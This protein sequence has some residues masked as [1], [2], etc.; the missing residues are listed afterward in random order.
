MPTPKRQISKKPSEHGPA[1][2]TDVARLETLLAQ[3]LAALRQ[4]RTQ[5]TVGNISGSGIA[6]GTGASAAIVHPSELEAL[7]SLAVDGNARRKEEIYLTWFILGNT[8]A[9]WEREYLPLASSLRYYNLSDAS[10]SQAGLPLDDVRDA[11]RQYHTERLVILGE[12]GAGKTT[13]LYRLAHDLARER[14]RDPAQG[15]LPISLSLANF[16]KADELPADFLLSQWANT[17]LG[18]TYGEAIAYGQACFLLD[19]LNQMPAEDRNKRIDDWRRWAKSESE[20]PA[21]NLAIFACRKAE[22]A[23]LLQLA[24]V[25]VQQLDNDRIQKY[26]HLRFDPEP[27]HKHWRALRD[28]L[29]TGDK[30]FEDLARNAMMLSLLADRAAKGQSLA[31]SKGVILEDAAV[32]RLAYEIDSDNQP[33][34][35]RVKAEAT[36]AAEME[37]LGRI[38]YEVQ[39]V[40]EGTVFDRAA[41]EA[42]PLSTKSPARLTLDQALKL[43]VDSTLLN[44]LGPDDGPPY[45]FRHQLFQEYFAARELLRRFR[46][47]EVLD[48][49]WQ[50]DWQAPDG[51]PGAER[52]DPPPATRWDETVVMLGGL[53]RADAPRLIAAIRAT[54]PP[55][56]GRALAEA[57]PDERDDLKGLADALRG[58]LLERQR[59]LGAR[60]RARISAGLALG[61]LGH[62]DLRPREFEFEGRKVS[63]IAPPMKHV[64]EGEFIRGSAPEE[65]DSFDQE[66]TTERRLTLPAYSAA[67]YPVTNA[68]YRLFIEDGGYDAKGWWSEA[69]WLWRGGG[70]DAHDAA[71]EQWLGTRDLFKRVPDWA[72]QLQR[73]GRTQGTINF[74]KEVVELT[75]EKARDRGRQQFSRS[76][77]RPAFWEDTTLNSPAKPVIGVNWHEAEAY[78]RWLSAVTSHEFRLPSEM[79]WEKAARGTDGR[80]YPWEGEF[81]SARCNTNEGRILNTTPV[82]LYPNGVSPYGLHDASGNVWEWTAD[83]YQ[84]YPG[85]PANDDYGERF[86]AVRGGSWDDNH[87]DA[88]CAFRF[89]LVPVSFLNTLGYRLFSPVSA[90]SAS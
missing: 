33:S 90:I 77:D 70:A 32:D 8:Y 1:N 14:L 74:W 89:R 65:E 53:A 36:L 27:G 45:E 30:R 6:I 26:F 80:Q 87:W 3:I 63:A 67:R 60:I 12:P 58:E 47:G 5:I 75:D 84:A 49:H 48:S 4:P 62:P 68:E 61:E 59:D 28:R 11:I 44:A 57:R 20:L 82:G 34:A 2:A 16:R 17:G 13:T 23:P 51:E 38:A 83:W 52:L 78:A 15:K 18:Q 19:G 86:K 42:I 81:D 40:G 56:A 54:H 7:R 31:D 55:L 69:G 29:R 35:F 76:F 39:V 22:Y 64:P 43:G 66:H 37:A 24:E 88:R 9:R 41:V 10:I 21:G 46:A 50:V 73:L 79:E 71:I 25:H 72:E 85:G